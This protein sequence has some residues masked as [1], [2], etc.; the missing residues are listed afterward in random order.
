MHLLATTSGVIDGAAEALDLNQSP[1]DLVVLSAADSEIASLATAF[2][3]LRH[4]GLRLANYLQLQHPLSVD[5]YIEKTLRLSPVFPF[6][7]VFSANNLGNYSEPMLRALLLRLIRPAEW[8]TKNRAKMTAQVM[9]Y[10]SDGRHDVLLGE[11]LLAVDR[12]IV[13]RPGRRQFDAWFSEPLG[14]ICE[15]VRDVLGV[16]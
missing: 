3:E 14:E 1:A 2:D 6:G 12:G 8:G 11:Y 15:D 4:P 7:T 5:L 9:E 10:L 13:T 16:R